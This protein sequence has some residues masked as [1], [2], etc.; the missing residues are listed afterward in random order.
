[1]KWFMMFFIVAVSSNLHAERSFSNIFVAF[2]AIDTRSIDLDFDGDGVSFGGQLEVGKQI[3]LLFVSNRF[4]YQGEDSTFRYEIS[5]DQNLFG[6]G[7]YFS[8]GD[9]SKIDFSFATGRPSQDLTQTRKTSGTSSKSS[10]D[11]TQGQSISLSYLYQLTEGISMSVAAIY[12]DVG[13]FEETGFFVDMVYS[14]A[15]NIELG[16]SVSEI[17]E[18]S[19]IALIAKYAL[20]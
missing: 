17:D 5:S 8:V 18:S 4:E 1:M 11:L 16:V 14:S 19:Q 20:K 3:Y 9:K 15:N 10:E 13:V 6:V 2:S 7:R 12:Q